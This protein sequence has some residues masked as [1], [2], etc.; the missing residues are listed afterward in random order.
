[1]E[2]NFKNIGPFPSILSIRIGLF[3]LLEILWVGVLGIFR[4][5]EGLPD[6]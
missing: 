5:R 6:K 1:M 2:I 4:L 3:T